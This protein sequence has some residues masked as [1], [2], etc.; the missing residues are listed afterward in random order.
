MYKDKKFWDRIAS[1]FDRIKK[2]DIA[3]KIFVDKAREY[4]KENHTIL[5]F[6]VQ[7]LFATRKSRNNYA[8]S[9]FRYF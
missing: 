2:N 7:G 4:L 6:M 5:D 1:K 3:Y 8:S 9:S